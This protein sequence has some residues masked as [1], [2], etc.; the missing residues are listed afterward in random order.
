MH[1]KNFSSDLPYTVIWFT[2]Q[3]SE[4]LEIEDKIDIALGL[5]ESVKLKKYST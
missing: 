3:N 5:N 4:P 1:F 2:N